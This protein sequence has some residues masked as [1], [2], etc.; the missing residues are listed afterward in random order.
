VAAP[1]EFVSEMAA[2]ESS[3][4]GDKYFHYSF[5]RPEN[6]GVRSKSAGAT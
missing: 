1:D 6:A 3:D 5:S 2:E 4:S